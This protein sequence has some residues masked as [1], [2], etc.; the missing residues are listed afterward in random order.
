MAIRVTHFPFAE[1][2]HMNAYLA[3]CPG[4]RRGLLV[5]PGDWDDR[6]EQFVEGEGLAVEGILLTH[7]HWDHTGGLAR[8]IEH[9]GGTLMA[10]EQ[11]L[12][13]VREHIGSSATRPLHEGDIIDM[14]G[15]QAHVYEVPGHI[16]D[17]IIVH[18]DGHVLA[19]DTLFAA[20]LGGTADETAFHLQAG[21]LQKILYHLPPDTVVH[22]G[23]GPVTE[24][25]LEMIF[26]PFLKGV[27]A[28]WKGALGGW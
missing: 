2:N 3:W 13:R 18:V 4:S 10:S 27:E 12:F 17:Q 23:H 1:A 21:K 8:A 7:S 14:G 22:P 25:G 24:V 6:I 11:A 5:D 20:A 15:H 28:R 19:G 26:N 16:D 9:L